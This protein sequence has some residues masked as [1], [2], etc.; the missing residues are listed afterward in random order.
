MAWLTDGVIPSRGRVVCVRFG[1]GRCRFRFWAIQEPSNC[2]FLVFRENF[3]KKAAGK[4]IS[5][6]VGHE[7]CNPPRGPIVLSCRCLAIENH[8]GGPSGCGWGNLCITLTQGS[9]TWY[10]RGTRS[11]PRTTWVVCAPVR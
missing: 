9:P 11:P 4:S 2:F 1:V 6:Y 8:H 10:L 7:I 5:S 3:A